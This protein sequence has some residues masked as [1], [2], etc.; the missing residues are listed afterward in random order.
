MRQN[1]ITEFVTRRQ[2]HAS[3]S[4]ELNISHQPVLSKKVRT[5][6]LCQVV[7]LADCAPDHRDQALLFA[8]IGI[9]LMAC[10]FKQY[11][12]KC[13][14]ERVC[15][16]QVTDSIIRVV[17]SWVLSLF[18][19]VGRLAWHSYPDVEGVECPTIRLSFVTATEEQLEEAISRIATVIKSYHQSHKALCA[20]N[21]I[22]GSATT[23]ITAT[24]S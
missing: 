18:C 23:T 16:S 8:W 15:L 3:N 11:T 24:A 12:Y 6:Q 14:S 17:G 4:C 21:I 5:S 9:L 13:L 19:C 1:D 7:S 2:G 20:N 10:S 22:T